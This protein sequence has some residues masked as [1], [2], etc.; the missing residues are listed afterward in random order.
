MV[1]VSRGKVVSFDR[2]KGY[3]F[4]TPEDGG[5]DVFIHVNDL[6]SDKSLLT[7]GSIVEYSLEEG[8]RGPKA[9]SVTVIQTG[10]PSA[11]RLTPGSLQDRPAATAGIDGEELCDVLSADEFSHEITEALL[12]TEPTLTGEQIRDSR[13]RLLSIARSHGWL[14]R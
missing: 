8:D 3:G 12:C 11:I 14:D 5:D 13:R 1:V 6:F 4:V 2:I 10:Q 7:A 9:S